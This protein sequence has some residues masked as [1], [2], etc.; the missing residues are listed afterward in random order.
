MGLEKLPYPARVVPPPANASA[1]YMQHANPTPGTSKDE[2]GSTMHE[3][4]KQPDA[5]SPCTLEQSALP[6]RALVSSLAILS[7]SMLVKNVLVGGKIAAAHLDTC[8]THCFLSTSMSKQLSKSGYPSILSPVQ[9]NVEQGVPLCVTSTV[10]ILPLTIIDAQGEPASW[11]ATL[12]VVADCGAD[13]II[14]YP[15]LSLGGIVDYNPP[16]GYTAKLQAIASSLP[17]AD[18]MQHHARRILNSGKT[19]HYDGPEEGSFAKNVRKTGSF[20]DE[21]LEDGFVSCSRT[22]KASTPS[23][24][25]EKLPSTPLVHKHA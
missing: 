21:F 25:R 2:P 15:I 13:V 16:E 11:R 7:Q 3:R 23:C 1:S 19:Y 8:A 22:N 24:S 5:T 17:A 20:S 18:E 4:G 10:H 14:C 9:Y 12:F 6:V